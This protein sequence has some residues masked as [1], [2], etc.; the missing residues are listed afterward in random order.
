MKGTIECKEYIMMFSDLKSL[1]ELQGMEC[2]YFN[3]LRTEFRHQFLNP[4]N[5]SLSERMN[6]KSDELDSIDSENIGMYC[7]FV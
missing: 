4:K 5:N 3:N 7:I 2:I 6:I 1:C